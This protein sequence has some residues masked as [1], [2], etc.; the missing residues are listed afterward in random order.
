[1][2]MRS[3]FPKRPWCAALA[4]FFSGHVF[5]ADRSVLPDE[6]FATG[7]QGTA[8]SG[9]GTALIFDQAAIHINP[10]MLFAHK[11]YDVNGTYIWPR[12]GRPF[13]KVAAIDGQTSKWTTA[14][15]YTGFTEGL[16][17]REKR[18][19][20]SPVR[21]R[22]SLAFA[23]PSDRFV[24]GFAGHYVEADDPTR[25]QEQTVKGFTLGSGLVVPLAGGLRLGASVDHFNN[26]KLQSVSPRTVRAGLAWED[27]TGSIALHGDYRV[28]ERSEYLEGLQLTESNGLAARAPGTEPQRL[29]SE[30]MVI[31]GAQMQTF[32]LLR[33]FISGGRSVS[34]EKTQITSGGLGLYQKNFSLAYAVSRTY[35]NTQEL[36]NSLSLSIT[37]KM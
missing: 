25:E 12:E 4:F 36:Q 15:E 14:F 32:D 17:S 31:L 21:R 23:L 22:A 26:E 20:D 18:E 29:E 2:L 5:P 27:K 19:Q 7:G 16:E 6:I 28:R 35:P 8:H 33:V 30:K 34:G 13:Y 1:M 9:A 10:A 11:T 37:M 3:L 24:L